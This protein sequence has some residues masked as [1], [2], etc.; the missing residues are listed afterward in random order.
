MN[1]LTNDHKLLKELIETA[2]LNGLRQ[3]LKD[4][5]SLANKGLP[6]DEEN[7]AE[8]PPLHRICD[9]V[10]A[11]KITDEQAV[12]IARIFI[13]A[14][15]GIDGGVLQTN[16]DTP[17]VAAASLHAD[18]VALLYIESGANIFHAGCHGGTALHWAA[19]C[20]RDQVVKKLIDEGAEI[21]KLCGEFKSTPVFW[22]VHGLRFGG[23]KNQHHQAECVK[24]LLKADADKNISNFEGYKPIELL[25]EEHLELQQLLK[26]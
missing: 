23:E 22:A 7:T 8:A 5:P 19:W 16:K 3:I 25:R 4:N 18:K 11:E 10:F 20:G 12:E 1:S 26:E 24:L 14:G 13:E 21:N 2:D 6:F 9:A 17:L 15:A